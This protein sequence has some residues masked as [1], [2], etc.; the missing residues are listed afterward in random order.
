MEET[1]SVQS[2]PSSQETRIVPKIICN[3]LYWLLKFTSS[4]IYLKQVKTESLYTQGSWLEHKLHNWARLISGRAHSGP[5]KPRKIAILFPWQVTCHLSC[6]DKSGGQWHAIAVGPG[7]WLGLWQAV[8]KVKQQNSCGCFALQA[9]KSSLCL[10]RG[11]IATLASQ[12]D[13]FPAVSASP[14]SFKLLNFFT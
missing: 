3:L 9:C 2:Y 1:S 11:F 13:T 7:L 8:V 10:C 6:R 5:L 4:E 12:S 14:S